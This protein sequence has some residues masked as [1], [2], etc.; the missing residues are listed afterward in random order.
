MQK[1]HFRFRYYNNNK[2]IP[3]YSAHIQSADKSDYLCSCSGLSKAIDPYGYHTIIWRVVKLEV[4]RFVSYILY[5]YKQG[6]R[7]ATPS[8]VYIPRTT[9]TSTT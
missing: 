2:D 1:K 8:P 3:Q 6:L 5:L 4:E 9:S 7:G